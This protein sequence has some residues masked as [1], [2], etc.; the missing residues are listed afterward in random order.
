MYRTLFLV[1]KP[2]V[3]MFLGNCDAALESLL[4]RSGQLL[5][6]DDCTDD[7]CRSLML[8]A[9]S[10]ERDLSATILSYLRSRVI[11]VRMLLQASVVA[12]SIAGGC[13]IRG[14]ESL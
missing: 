5:W 9:G 11:P 7:Y 13:A 14:C 3:N 6:P 10:T 8:R 1:L 4:L 12:G 2:L